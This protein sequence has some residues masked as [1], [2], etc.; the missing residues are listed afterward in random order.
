MPLAGRC[1]ALL[2]CTTAAAAF[3]AAPAI[4][5]AAAPESLPGCADTPTVQPFAPWQDVAD[6]VLAPGGDFEDGAATWSL[7]GGAAAVEGNEPFQVGDA[8]DHLA[9]SIPAGATATTSPTCIGVEHRTM[10]MFVRGSGALR[11][12][13]VYDDGER[14][15]TLGIVQ[16][17]AD[18]APSQIVAMKVNKLAADYD[19]AM[20]VALR[21]TSS[22]GADVTIDDVYVDPFRV[23]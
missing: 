22:P 7:T 6:Y 15:K 17:P 18:W 1:R 5:G 13:A 16:A 4:A 23:R 3:A 9:L 14:S 2:A 20:Q 8:G 11:V 21:F 12:D 19:N 10:R